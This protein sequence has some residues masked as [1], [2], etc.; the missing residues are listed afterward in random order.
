MSFK[1]PRPLPSNRQ[2]L[3]CGDCL[4][5]KMGRLFDQLCAVVHHNCARHMHTFTVD[6]IGL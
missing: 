3:S 4:E 5:V 6:W 2:H 1:M